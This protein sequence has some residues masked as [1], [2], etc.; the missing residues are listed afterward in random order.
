VAGRQ[1]VAAALAQHR[2]ILQDLGAYL[3]HAA[4]GER[5]LVVDAAMQNHLVTEILFE[6]VTLSAK[7]VRRFNQK[8]T[9]GEEPC[10]A[11]PTCYAGGREEGGSATHAGKKLAAEADEFWL[12]QLH[13]LRDEV[14]AD[15]LKV[16]DDEAADGLEGFVHGAGAVRR[17]DGV[18]DAADGMVFG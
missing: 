4:K 6:R 11:L 5:V 10:V 8:Y 13:P 17:E 16:V 1:D 7:A 18:L 9:P 3:V 12:G 2:E 14:A 15:G